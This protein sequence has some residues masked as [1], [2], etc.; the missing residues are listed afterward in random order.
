M[1]TETRTKDF[2][3]VI[4]ERQSVRSYHPDVKIPRDELKEMIQ[5]ASEAPSSWNLQHWKFLVFDESEAKQALLPIAYGQQ[6]I[7][8]ASAVI[9]ILGDVEADKNAEEVFSAAVEA[10]HAPQ[11]V[12]ESMVDQI[13]TAYE[14]IPNIGRDE[15]IR[16]AS[17][18]AMQFM[19]VAKAYDYDTCPIGGFDRNEL[20]KQFNIPE[21][22]I[23]IMLIT[24]GKRKADAHETMRFS[25]DE[26]TVW[27]TF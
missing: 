10:G 8:D 13:K 9:A 24:I 12:K 25:G 19:L 26:I 15:A 14:T 7:V 17:L 5:L 3:T 21:R 18:G 6:Q 2:F 27:N 23:P 16:N 1:V 22:F 4:Q 20:V 11:S